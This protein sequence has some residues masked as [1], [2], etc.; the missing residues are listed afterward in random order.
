MQMERIKLHKQ[1]YMAAVKALSIAR[2]FN[3]LLDEETVELKHFMLLV[4]F[5]EEQPANALTGYFVFRNTVFR[6]LTATIDYALLLTDKRFEGIEYFKHSQY[7]EKLRPN[8]FV[9][10]VYVVMKQ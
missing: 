8:L 4:N 7:T 1:F 10:F 6:F 5:R 9:I 3:P 2:R